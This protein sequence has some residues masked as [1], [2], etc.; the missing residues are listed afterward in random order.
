MR[1]RFSP[2]MACLLLLL[3]MKMGNSVRGQPVAA[4][5]LTGKVVCGYQGWFRCDGD[6]A[7][8][9][10]HHYAVGGKF[11]PGHAHIDIWPDVHELPAE[12]RFATQ[13]RLSDG[14]RAEVF[15]SYRAS[16]VNLHFR[17]MRDYG[18]D[19]IF[20]QR[21]ATDA[22]DPRFRAPMNTIL[23]HCRQAAHRYGRNWGIMYDLSGCTPND[24]DGVI[25][26]W[27]NLLREK[28]LFR[29]GSD[30]AYFRH[31]H[32]PL[33]ALWGLG[34]ADREPML[35]DWE[36]LI[37]FLRHD[38][39]FGGF[40]VMLGVPY[41]WRSLAQDA[42]SDPRLHRLLATGDILCP[43]SVGRL[44]TVQDA[45]ARQESHLAPD[46]AMARSL[47]V[48]Y[49]PVIFPGFSWQNLSRARGQDAPLNA[50]P[51]DAGD[52][53]WAQAVAAKKAGSQ[54]LYV[55]MFDELD[56]GTAIFKTLNNP[57]IGTSRFLAEPGLPSDHYLWL[58]GQIG[59]M[60]RGEIPAEASQPK[61][62]T[63]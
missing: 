46:I 32:K 3:V 4:S 8:N 50:I 60:L 47:K 28:R 39:E 35:P 23:D 15:S 45:Q 34:F 56:E 18:I 54:M 55:A 7:N 62:M 52:F 5:T 6:G 49:L 27:K 21:F 36:R 25:E 48:D 13:F 33:I 37:H 40:A 43:W 38:P 42:I 12:D 63:P 58:T 41:H 1:L 44:A 57:P 53:L 30:A 11:E 19:G 9:G 10:W 16:T 29:D 59:R 61:R 31:N 26:D 14:S 51:R 20:L 2:A 22:R 24:I 17:W